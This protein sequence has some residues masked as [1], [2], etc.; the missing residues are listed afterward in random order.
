MNSAFRTLGVAIATV[1][2]LATIGC[3]YAHAPSGTTTTVPP[4]AISAA[5]QPSSSHAE[6]RVDGAITA[7]DGTSVTV[8]G[9]PMRFTVT[10]VND[11]PDIAPV[12]LVV[13]LGHCSC[14]PP[15]ARMMAEGSMRML[16][17]RTNEWVEAPYVREGT[18]MDYVYG[19]LVKPFP[20]A[21]GQTA[22][23]Q[24]EMQLN[25]DQSFPVTDGESAIHVMLTDPDDPLDHPRVGVAHLRFTVDA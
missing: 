21:H 17:P 5:P 10:L 2:V 9:P 18:G 13:S 14:G 4:A 1:A 23:Y 8:G 11:G 3:S 6:E 15:G 19:N 12:G 7:Q 24:L 20:L 25:A 22:T 16:D